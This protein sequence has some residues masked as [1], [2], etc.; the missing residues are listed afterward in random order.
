MEQFTQKT[1]MGREL[2]Y[3]QTLSDATKTA[4]TNLLQLVKIGKHYKPGQ[5]NSQLS[6]FSTVKSLQF[7]SFSFSITEQK[8]LLI[9][10]GIQL[11]F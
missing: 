10:T 2:I 7:V 1:N 3:S 5:F 11:G 9:V 6:G 4:Q 8:N